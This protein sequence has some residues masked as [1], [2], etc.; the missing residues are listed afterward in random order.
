[1]RSDKLGIAAIFKNEHPFIVEWL[2]YHRVLGI[3]KFF[4]ADNESDDDTGRLLAA[5]SSL[6]YLKFITHKTNLGEKP[7]MA[8]YQTLADTFKN[9]VEWLCYIDADEFLQPETEGQSIT[10]ALSEVLADN[11]VGA[12]AINWA[13]YGSSNWVTADSRPIIERFTLRAKKE[14]GANRHYKTIIRTEA[15]R[16]SGGNPHAFVLEDGYKYVNGRG[17]RLSVG[18]IDGIAD[19][20]T[21]NPVRINH[22]VVK[23]RSEFFTKKRPRGRPNG[24]LRPVGFFAQ[25]DINEE[26]EEFSQS[27]I[28]AVVEEKN[29]IISRLDREIGYVLV[30]ANQN[31]FEV[32]F[33]K[34]GESLKMC[35]DGAKKENGKIKCHGW[36]VGDE[37]E[38]SDFKILV[39]YTKVFHANYVNRKLRPDVAAAFKINPEQKYGFECE[40]ECDE[41]LPVVDAAS[42]LEICVGAGRQN[43]AVIVPLIIKE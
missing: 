27:F 10:D 12:V 24:D 16:S 35:I 33:S 21:W 9:E 19:S 15:F 37:G 1:M 8:A 2:A 26:K 41:L 20:V 13:L 5:L 42:T 43:A 11:E 39:D 14:C 36:V 7:Q 31:T 4:I 29:K 38:A 40:F 30:A 6:G 32:L 25:H 34:G 17:R 18:E 28:N 23:S 3:S 22:Y